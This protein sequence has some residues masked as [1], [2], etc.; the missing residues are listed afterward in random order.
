MNEATFI[1]QNSGKWK[2]FE[3]LIKK[4]KAID[5]DKLAEIYIRI[6]DDLA[7]ARTHFENSELTPYLNNLASGIHLSIY[8]NKKEDSSRFL[9]FWKYELPK[10]MSGSLK[11]VFI[12]FVVFSLSGAVGALSAAHDDTFVRLILG[13]QYVNETISNIQKGDPMAVYKQ[14]GQTEMFLGITFNNIRV[15]FLVF[16]AGV[17]TSF[18]TGYLLFMNGVMLGAFQYFFYQK[19]LFVTS[20]LT[21]WIHGTLEI[22]AIIIA[23][24]AGIIMGNGL[25]FPGTYSRL[26]SFRRGAKRGLKIIIGLIPVFIL[27]GFLEGFVTRLTHMPDLIKISIILGSAIFIFIYFIFIPVKIRL[28]GN[29][30][31]DRIL[32]S[33]EL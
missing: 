21:I 26:Y 33:Q 23:G 6:T 16:V 18:A 32:Q 4:S 15:S 10:V 17:F 31:E 7:F 19:G 29:P 8:K 3:K 24:A 12:S 20:A 9:T 27:A 5:A 13:D 22:S 25:L 14:V 30:S 28:N 2:E 1:K 11:Y